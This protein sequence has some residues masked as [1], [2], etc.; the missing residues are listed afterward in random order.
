MD[1]QESIDHLH[2]IG[3]SH[4]DVQ[5]ENICFNDSYK[6]VFINLERCMEFSKIH[7]M[8]TLD[9]PAA[10]CTYSPSDLNS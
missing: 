5:L 8:F 9:L 10:A 6:V 1:I 4:N 2:G 3:L 7:P